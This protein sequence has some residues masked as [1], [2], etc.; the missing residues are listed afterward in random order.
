MGGGFALAASFQ[1]TGLAQWLAG[2]FSILEFLPLPV[3]LLALCLLVTFLT[4]VTSNTATAVVLMPILAASATILDIHPFL[5]M[6]PATL[7]A[8]FAFM[9]PVATPPNA[10]VFASGHVTVR[11]MSRAG[12]VL[13]LLGALLVAVMMLFWGRWVFGI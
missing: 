1:S 10:I 9:L 7:S 8:S 2:Q 6:I 12:F 3:L 11:D 13:N 4:E 5:L